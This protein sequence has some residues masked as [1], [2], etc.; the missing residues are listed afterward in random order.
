MPG[1]SPMSQPPT[2]QGNSRPKEKD[3]TEYLQR[4]PDAADEKHIK[5]S[6]SLRTTLARRKH[7]DQNSQGLVEAVYRPFCRQQA[8]FDRYLNHERSQ[9]PT[10]FPTPHHANVGFYTL[11]VG[12]T[13]DFAL[14]ISDKLPDVQMLGAGQNGQFF[15]RWTY[16]H[17]VDDGGL[18]F[19]DGQ[20]VDEWGYRRVD[21]I[22]DDILAL[23]RDTVG[24]QVSKDDIFF[25][26]YGVLHDPDYRIRYAADLKK[27][28]P[29]IPTPD[30]AERFNNVAVIGRDLAEI[31]VNYE[32]AQPYPLDVQLKAGTDP[33]SRETWRVDKMRWRSK[34]DKSAILYNGRVTIDGI[35]DQAHDYLLGSRTALE[36]LIDRYRIK[37]DKASGIVND[38]NTWCDEHDDPTYIVELIKKV[39][40]VSVETVKLVDRL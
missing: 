36:W 4:H 34:T 14:L 27:M 24:D 15:P 37:T 26:V 39:T 16:V 8:Y 18:D 21:N 22:T 40:T 25:Y 3:V 6:R 30:T 17:A 28:L 7:V 20:D 12:A 2:G 1:V 38:P 29:H 32:V 10:M 35:P 23:Y 11:G 13:A 33:N 31:H 19:T 5:W 9:L